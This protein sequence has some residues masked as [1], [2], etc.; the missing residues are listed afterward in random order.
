[1]TLMVLGLVLFLGIHSISIFS[2]SWRDR[3]VAAIGEWPWKGIYSVL[4]LAGLVM[5]SR[6]YELARMDPV[7]LYSP[8][9]WLKHASLLLLLFVFPLLF[10]AY[11]PGRI[12]AAVKHPMLLAVKI[13]ALGHLLVNGTLADVVLFGSFLLWAGADRMSMKQREQRAIPGA[14]PSRAN[15]LIA[16]VGGVAVY[17]VFV[18]WLH[19]WLIGIKP[20]A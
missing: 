15:D 20:V 17:V 2:V 8:P 12:K 1:M 14:P 7:Y 18:L 4:S 11:F 16:V 10:A 3:M 9:L 13:W 5:I 19:Q 6:G